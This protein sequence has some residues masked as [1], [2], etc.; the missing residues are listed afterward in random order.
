M[1][2]N[3]NTIPVGSEFPRYLAEVPRTHDACHISVLLLSHPER[4]QAQ[5]KIGATKSSLQASRMIRDLI[6]KR[7]K[8][9]DL[10]GDDGEVLPI[11]SEVM[12]IIHPR[13]TER[14]YNIIMGFEAGDEDPADAP[15][16]ED[17]EANVDAIFGEK[18]KEQAR[19]ENDLKN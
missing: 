14:L 15:T 17:S 18:T 10:T 8:S 6:S 16:K 13:M 1:A 5:E 3:R 11:T 7:M 9:W 4:Y 2:K 19:E 12:E